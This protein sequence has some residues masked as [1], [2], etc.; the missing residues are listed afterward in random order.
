MDFPNISF[1]R[2]LD[3]LLAELSGCDEHVDACGC[4]LLSRLTVKIVFLFPQLQHIPHNSNFSLIASTLSHDFE[5]YF[6]RFWIAV[7]AVVI[8]MNAIEGK[9]HTSVFIRLQFRNSIQDL[10]PL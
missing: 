7:I 6:Q 1:L 10:A 5:T 8:N 2:R 9:Q 3:H 4:N